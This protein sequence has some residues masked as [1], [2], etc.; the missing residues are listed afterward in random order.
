MKEKFEIKP[1][2]FEAMT[3]ILSAGAFVVKPFSNYIVTLNT[4]DVTEVEQYCESVT[5]VLAK[6]MSAMLDESLARM[7]TGAEAKLC[8]VCGKWMDVIH[9]S[10]ELT[11]W[12]CPNKH[13]KAV[14]RR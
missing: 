1:Y 13:R 5:K 9:R 11:H 7:M 12:A 10:Q 8:R 3:P 14:K 2:Q 4:D 6:E